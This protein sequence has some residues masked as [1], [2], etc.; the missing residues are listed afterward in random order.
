MVV[1]NNSCFLFG[2]LFLKIDKI[3]PKKLLHGTVGCA[4]SKALIQKSQVLLKCLSLTA[5]CFLGS[6]AQ[7]IISTMGHRTPADY[8]Q[9]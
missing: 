6:P 9:I 2:E 8:G 3:C 5:N 7:G 4:S 1:C